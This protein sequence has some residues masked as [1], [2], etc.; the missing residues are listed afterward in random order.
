MSKPE[1]INLS[2]V[3]EQIEPKFRSRYVQRLCKAAQK[4]E[5][6]ALPVEKSFKVRMTSYREYLVRNDERFKRWHAQTLKE[7]ELTT[8]RGVA[9]FEEDVR[10]GEV[11]FESRLAE[12]QKSLKRKPRGKPRKPKLGEASLGEG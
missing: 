10:S 2:G 7:L 3:V 8:M 4:S 12:Y 9:A 11:D 6:D 1:L 5:V